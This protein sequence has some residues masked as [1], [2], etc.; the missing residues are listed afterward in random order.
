MDIFSGS[1]FAFVK[2]PIQEM[3]NFF[4]AASV[5]FV[6]VL[7]VITF[8]FFGQITTSTL[9]GKMKD[10][11][12]EEILGASVIMIHTTTG[13]RYGVSTQI[14]GNFVLANMNPGGPYTLSVSFLGYK[15]FKVKIGNFTSGSINA[16]TRTGNNQVK[17]Y[18]YGYGRNAF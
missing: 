15:P 18:V 7:S 9:S 10:T 3:Y 2:K 8:D 11:K 17:G 12:G 14:D 6:L 5:Q 4:K 16:V 1:N 13:A